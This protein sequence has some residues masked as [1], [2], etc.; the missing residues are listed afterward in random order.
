MLTAAP[1]EL[2]L[3]IANASL[4]LKGQDWDAN[5]RAI[6]KA[7]DLAAGNGDHLLCF[8]ELTLT[9]ADCADSF[10]YSDNAKIRELLQYVADYAAA[11]NLIIS[12]GHPWYYA[13]KKISTEGDAHRQSTA[14]FNRE[15]KPFVA[16]S[17]LAGGQIIAMS[18]KTA[19]EK[20][21]YFSRHFTQW[22]E[23]KT[24]ANSV[25]LISLPEMTYYDA[26]QEESITI[27]AQEI[28]FGCPVVD[29]TIKVAGE[30]QSVKITQIIGN[31][32]MKAAKDS[33]ASEELSALLSTAT[34]VLNPHSGVPVS[35]AQ[36]MEEDAEKIAKISGEQILVCTSN[37]GNAGAEY[38]SNGHR[39]IAMKG[40]KVTDTDFSGFGDVSYSS[41]VLTSGNLLPESFQGI[42]F[43]ES[44]PEY[45]QTEDNEKLVQENLDQIEFKLEMLNQAQWLFDYLRKSA[46]KYLTIAFS[47]DLNSA[48]SAAKV[49]V[50]VELVINELGV[51]KFISQMGLFEI[52]AFK[53]PDGTEFKDL[54]RAEQINIIMKKMLTCVYCFDKNTTPEEI[55]QAKAFVE[56]LGGTF[57]QHDIQPEMDKFKSWYLAENPTETLSEETIAKTKNRLS[58]MIAAEI[59]NLAVGSVG[60]ACS[61]LDDLCGNDFIYGGDLHGGQLGLNAQKWRIEQ[62]DDMMRLARGELKSAGVSAIDFDAILA[63]E[64]QKQ[65]VLKANGELTSEQTRQI[66]SLMLLEKPEA[67][68]RKNNPFEVF[69]KCYGTPAFVSGYDANGK[70]I[71]E[72]TESVYNKIKQCYKNWE[73]AQIGIH[74]KPLSPDYDRKGIN[75]D[76]ALRTPNIN[77]FH[78]QEVAQLALHCLLKEEKITEEL[79]T[80]L[81]DRALIDDKLATGLL[82]KPFSELNDSEISR[83]T[84]VCRGGPTCP[85]SSEANRQR[86]PTGEEPLQQ[87]LLTL[88]DDDQD[89]ENVALKIAIASCNQTGQNW[90]RNVKNICEA[91][92]KAVEDGADLLALQELGLSGYDCDDTFEYTNNDQ[93]H[94]LLKIIANYAASKNPNLMISIGHPWKLEPK[95]NPV[96]DG[97]T[98]PFNVQT[99]LSN[100]EIISMSAK[101]YLYNYTRGYEKRHFQEW[102]D[103][104]ANEFGK[105][106]GRPVNDG[107][108]QIKID[109][110]S[111]PFGSPVTQV[112]SPNGKKRINVFQVICEESWIGS[113]FNGNDG[114]EAM[115]AQDNP[116]AI[117]NKKTQ[118]SIALN[119]NGSPPSAGKHDKSRTLARWGS[120]HCGAFVHS[121]FLGTESLSMVGLGTSMIA[122]DGKIISDAPMLST[123]NVSYSSQV[124]S[125]KSVKAVQT[126]APDTIIHHD[127]SKADEHTS[128]INNKPAAWLIALEAEKLALNKELKL[129]QQR[130]VTLNAS[131]KPNYFSKS[132]CKQKIQKL[133]EKI[134]QVQDNI[135]LEM[136]IR[137]EVLWLFDYMRKNHIRGFTQ[138]LSGGAD[139]AYNAVKLRL[140]VQLVIQ[141]RG[142]NAFLDELHY[143]ESEKEAIKASWPEDKFS[144]DLGCDDMADRGTEEGKGV[145]NTVDKIMD[146]L[147][148]CAYLSTP[149]NSEDTKRAATTLIQGGSYV[150]DKGETIDYRG[151]GG[152]YTDYSIQSLVDEFLL[153]FAGIHIPKN[154]DASEEDYNTKRQAVLAKLNEYFKLNKSSLERV[155]NQKYKQYSELGADNPQSVSHW[156]AD[157]ETGFGFTRKTN[158]DGTFSETEAQAKS[159]AKSEREQ[160]LLRAVEAGFK[161][162]IHAILGTSEAEMMNIRTT[163]IDPYI[164]GTILSPINPNQGLTIENAQARIR[165][166]AILMITDHEGKQ[167]FSNPNLNEAVRSYTTFLGDLHSGHIGPNMHKHKFEQLKQMR[168]LST[169]GL[170]GIPPVASMYHV[171][172]N[173]PSAE[174]QP[175]DEND[176]VAQFD[177][178]AMGCTYEENRVFAHQMFGERPDDHP[179][180][181][182]NP[183]E[184]FEACEKMPLFA[185]FTVAQ[186]HEKILTSYKAWVLA[187]HKLRAAPPST[188]YGDGHYGDHKKSMKT[189]CVNAYHAP[190]LAQLALYC[191]AKMAKEKLE[192]A[193]GKAIRQELT[194]EEAFFALTGHS[195]AACMQHVLVDKAFAGKLEGAMW[196]DTNVE[197]LGTPRGR[198]LEALYT[199]IAT[200]HTK[201]FMADLFLEAKGNLAEKAK[202]VSKG[203]RLVRE[204]KA[205]D[206]SKSEGKSSGIDWARGPSLLST[207]SAE[208]SKS[209]GVKEVLATYNP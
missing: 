135:A 170:T 53:R 86:G 155:Y 154:D 121:N 113:T 33:I 139:S 44:F 110:K 61:N 62:Q 120:K 71:F 7:I 130:L 116:L 5:L 63:K 115:Y 144:M 199:K 108:I 152:K 156:P 69:E 159:R 24:G 70:A 206:E 160:K 30:L 40:Q 74:A 209:S 153:L 51:D 149:N 203:E 57:R 1:K 76:T 59:A 128:G 158:P 90:A 80:Q 66:F 94:R 65:A 11:K 125:V 117:K 197:K 49:R 107:T 174:L 88:T 42:D 104:A 168:L 46:L 13:N 118:I 187:Q 35:Y 183:I 39:F 179:E 56:T 167:G 192:K 172:N 196:T 43:I 163:K 72:S 6:Y 202:K 54:D 27:P 60:V 3:K 140:M 16:Q 77:G 4:N 28:Q 201:T 34:I 148:T 79:Y 129:T 180:R 81:F 151:I 68:G 185:Q 191:I 103:E 123:E 193:A 73:K 105:K 95:D 89:H 17:I 173:K 208:P 91:I 207:K 93:I 127:F 119:P 26:I 204:E 132:N 23:H 188:T 147:L 164:T 181:K 198:D 87:D 182:K 165:E 67:T 12:I 18:A 78:R 137:N 166:V 21:N 194:K 145:E 111:I 102:N 2:S 29:V 32:A 14:E 169:R 138:A 162:E 200:D 22:D 47:G 142:L 97:S 85:P 20:D 101:K 98:K 82:E 134:Q 161:A 64:A 31:E 96:D 8:G 36:Q 205:C 141:E 186:M 15:D 126:D 45:S 41:C 124:V 37:M 178:E 177:E 75:H 100:G 106:T 131:D 109:E 190:E 48:Y 195:L 114:S 176:E 136:E 99:I 122:Q 146:G 175:H 112:Q 133:Q 10:Q 189:P 157:W 84:D 92:D 19:F 50:M 25:I 9:S 171:V 38:S 150:N 143:P 55:D 83:I 52:K 58:V 184:I